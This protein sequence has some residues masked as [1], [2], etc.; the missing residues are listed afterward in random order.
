V[1]RRFASGDV[2]LR[3]S[4]E[5][6][7]GLV[8]IDPAHVEQVAINLVVNAIDS[9]GGSGDVVVRT[10]RVEVDGE[11]RLLLE[12]EDTGAGM[13]A[14]T[15]TKILE[16]YFT[17]KPIGQ[18]TG[19]GLPT[20]FGL[21]SQ[22]G[23]AI[24]VDSKVGTGTTV[25]VSLPCRVG[26][27]EELISDDVSGSI[28]ADGAGERV[29][30]V[31]DDQAVASFVRTA[32]ERL[33][34]KVFVAVSGTDALMVADEMNHQIDLLITDLMLPGLGGRV[35]ADRIRGVVPDLRVLF[36]SGFAGD[37]VR[38]GETLDT[39][40]SHFLAKPFGVGD[41]SQVVSDLLRR[42][43]VGGAWR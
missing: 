24:S 42:E 43:G 5:A 30:L 7:D 17:T 21:V 18:G 12:V 39:E 4:Y 8:R 13:D 22:A 26:Q 40:T 16:P 3:F 32:L 10:R 20:V 33:G 15:Q 6:T 27:P 11:L 23:G 1:L 14:A 38:E 37:L 31:E 2:R 25:T 41:L 19:L 34:Y 28:V 35:V 9:L 29:L 36:I